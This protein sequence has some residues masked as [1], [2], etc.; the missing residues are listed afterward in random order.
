MKFSL[1]KWNNAQK[2]EL[3]VHLLFWLLIFSTVKVDWRSDW[4]DPSLRPNS[5]A[6]LSVLI[7]P[8][9]FYAHAYWAIPRFLH[10]R[11]W[12]AYAASLVFI[13]LLPEV[14]RIMGLYLF[15]DQAWENELTS[16]DSFLFGS[17]SAGW[18]AF[19][20]SSG[21]RFTRDWFRHRQ[22]Q[23]TPA[24][25]AS[26]SHSAQ[27][28]LSPA[29]ARELQLILERLM[30]NDRPFLNDQLSLSSLAKELQTK[31]KKLSA[32]LNQYME[33]NF[34][35]YVNAHRIQLFLQEASRGAL[36]Q[37]TILGL[38]QKCGFSS[39]TSFYRAFK[40]E[41]QLTPSAYF[42]KKRSS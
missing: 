2:N 6:P 31:P 9:L 15:D 1:P 27:Q 22:D 4:L 30:Q 24:K 37:V 36:D 13:F 42:Q 32:L 19:I 18:L 17:P 28:I 12:L 33:T 3:A 35:D 25:P 7:F 10:P 41:T 21:Y 38:A 34:A 20:F 39:K 14:I 23:P 40:K 26:S 5:P 11:R 8:L 29:E 16:R